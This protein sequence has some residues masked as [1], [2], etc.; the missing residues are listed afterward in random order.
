MYHRVLLKISG[1]ALSSEQSVICR[2]TVLS[3]VNKIKAVRQKGIQ[4]GIVVGGGNI[5]RGRS[6]E[7]MERNR[8][9]HM[10]CWQR[11]S[12]RLRCKM[13]WKRRVFPAWCS[14]RWI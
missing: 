4:I 2:E 10:V 7:G 3:T 9:D 11:R 1:E 8:A 12:T 5:M 13:L 6:A 14:P